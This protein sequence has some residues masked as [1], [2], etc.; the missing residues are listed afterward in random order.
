MFHAHSLQTDESGLTGE[1]TPV[2]KHSDP[3]PHDTL[4]ADRL[5]MAYAGST[6]LAGKGAGFVIGTG[7]ATET[8]RIA[9]LIAGVA[10]LE[11]PL[12]RKMAHFSN[13]LLWGIGG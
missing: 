10:T 3:L 11:T 7:S 12:T 4:L 6:V 2:G 9:G 5:N 8:G 13:W 1:S